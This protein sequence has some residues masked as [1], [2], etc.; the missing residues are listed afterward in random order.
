MAL[1]KSIPNGLR[2][3]VF[4]GVTLFGALGL[5]L[6]LEAVNRLTETRPAKAFL[7]NV[8]DRRTGQSR[9]G[10]TYHTV[11]FAPVEWSQA[12]QSINDEELH[13]RLKIGDPVCGELHTGMLGW[14][15]WV[16]TPCRDEVPAP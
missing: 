11:S 12:P 3:G 1:R 10:S 7:A 14:R 8:V 5:G 4:S 9:D 15:W 13:E 2:I 16:L 6:S